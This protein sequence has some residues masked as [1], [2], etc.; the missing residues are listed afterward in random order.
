MSKNQ[1]RLPPAAACPS[2]AKRELTPLCSACQQL[3]STS[4][5]FFRSAPESFS[6]RRRSENLSRLPFAVNNLFRLFFKKLFR[7]ALLRLSGFARLCETFRPAAARTG[8]APLRPRC[9]RLLRVF[10]VFFSFPF[11]S[12]MFS[13]PL[14]AKEKNVPLSFSVPSRH[15][16][17]APR[18]IRR[19][20]LFSVHSF[21]T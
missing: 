12:T 11:V 21:T 18:Q 20:A 4:E 7:P 1:R 5:S 17:K 2:A 13:V 9:Q 6:P 15:K 16:Q 10:F 8:Y 3:F 14:R 19:R